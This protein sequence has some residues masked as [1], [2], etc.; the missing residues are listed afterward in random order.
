MSVGGAT[1]LA[2]RAVVITGAGRGL[3]RAFATDAARAG[4]RVVVDDVDE[5]AAAAVA[6]EIRQFGGSA[7]GVGWSVA[8]W[9]GAKA[10]VESCLSEYGRVDGLVN[11]AGTFHICDPW[12]DD[13]AHI[14]SLISVNVVGALYCG[15]H[16][17]RA[18]KD[19][20]RGGAILNVTSGAQAGDPT[21]ATYSASKGAVASLTY[22]WAIDLLPLSIRVNAIAPVAD[23]RMLEL[24]R[25]H[26]P[27][28]VTWPPERCAPLAT[29]LLSD[30]SRH[31]TGQVV[32]LFDRE[33]AV[34]SHPSLAAAVKADV[35]WTF[36]DIEAVFR[37][38]ELR[39]A[40][41]PIGL[42]AKEYQL[43]DI[44]PLAD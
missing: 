7:I 31:I 41:Q 27:S 32:R 13:Q 12:D 17:M 2:G 4:A 15:V 14:D 19:G 8:D 28:P 35:P 38:G 18:M 11:N 10:I 33:L 16:A 23:T 40:L 3:G 6:E 1:P 24:T 20:G 29:Y 22:S 26:R 9:D 30:N 37:A 39:T 5:E 25:Q 43:A 21:E 44:D 42:R 36:A 34:M